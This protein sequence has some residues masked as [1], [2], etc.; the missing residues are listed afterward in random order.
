MWLSVRVS[1]VNTHSL[2]RRTLCP[3]C[4]S[5]PRWAATVMNHDKV[6]EQDWWCPGCFALIKAAPAEAP[7]VFDHFQQESR[8]ARMN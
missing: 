4:G 2:E 3:C 5:R 1:V 8:I 6:V 7:Q